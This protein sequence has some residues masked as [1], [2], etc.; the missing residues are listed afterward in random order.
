MPL[1]KNLSKDVKEL[2][3][4]AV[5]N[6]DTYE[7][8]GQQFNVTK[9]AVWKIFKKWKEAGNVD[10]AK[11]SGRPSK[12]TKP[13]RRSLINIVQNNPRKNS[14]DVRKEAAVYGVSISTSTAQR[15]LR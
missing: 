2:I 8:V 13:M 15:L 3:V 6:G 7:K 11:R 5:N 14:T 9:S 12:L 1:T 10:A 4:R